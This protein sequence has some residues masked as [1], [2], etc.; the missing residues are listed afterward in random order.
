MSKEIK[1]HQEIGPAGKHRFW[2][3]HIETWKQSGI[4]QSAYCRGKSLSLRSFGYW[5]KKF[6]RKPPLTFVPVTI[7]RFLPPAYQPGTSLRLLTYSGYGIEIGDGF[8]PETLRKL[9]ET[10]AGGI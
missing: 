5:K 8:N 3:A 9:L 6:F 10:L 2:Q 4:N 7:K 1:D